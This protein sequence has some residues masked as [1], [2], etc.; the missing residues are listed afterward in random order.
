MKTAQRSPWATFSSTLAFCAT[1]DNMLDGGSTAMTPSVN[2][3]AGATTR[4]LEAFNHP[5]LT[6]MLSETKD[7][8]ADW[9]SYC[10]TLKEAE[11][12]LSC[13]FDGDDM[14]EAETHVEHAKEDEEEAR[15]E[16][17]RNLATLREGLEANLPTTAE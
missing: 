10:G 14:A 16:L 9:S 13:A 17:I 4:E 2:S 11:E 5:A 15:S 7:A 12:T 6:D 8:L 1:I 3:D